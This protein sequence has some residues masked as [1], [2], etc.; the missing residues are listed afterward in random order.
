M[1]LLVVTGLL[2]LSAGMGIGALLPPHHQHSTKKETVPHIKLLSPQ[3]P[4]PQ[5]VSVMSRKAV[6]NKKKVATKQVLPNDKILDFTDFDKSLLKLVENKSQAVKNQPQTPPPPPPQLKGG[7][8][9][10]RKSV[11]DNS[12]FYSPPTVVEDQLQGGATNNKKP[13][14]ETSWF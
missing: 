5:R 8:S 7:Q 4:I 9:T 3:S 12:E 1:A 2:S 10:L 6:A 11:V 14:F 13:Q